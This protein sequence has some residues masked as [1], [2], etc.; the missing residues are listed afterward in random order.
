[1]FSQKI[2]EPN[3]PFHGCVLSSEINGKKDSENYGNWVKSG[4]T[5]HISTSTWREG[6]ISIPTWATP[7]SIKGRL[8]MPLSSHVILGN[9]RCYQI[10][11]L[12]TNAMQ[13]GLVRGQSLIIA[14]WYMLSDHSATIHTPTSLQAQEQNIFSSSK[15]DANA[16][17]IL[18][19][20]RNKTS[21]I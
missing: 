12:K 16:F 21:N 8:K 15:W 1:M 19:T 5:V 13:F 14:F 9:R 17:K 3:L 10:F 6:S 4:T 11:P 18:S 2:L 7:E 20:C